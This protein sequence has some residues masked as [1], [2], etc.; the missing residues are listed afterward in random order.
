M[1]FKSDKQ[2]KYMFMKHPEIAEK[3]SKE[4]DDDKKKAKKKALG[5]IVMISFSKGKK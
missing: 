2:R 1:P 4:E 3:W 5:S